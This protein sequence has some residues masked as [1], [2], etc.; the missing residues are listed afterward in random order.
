M[1]SNFFFFGM[2]ALICLLNSSVAKAQIFAV[3]TPVL[4]FTER[5]Y[6]TE[7]HFEVCISGARPNSLVLLEAV[8]VPLTSELRAQVQVNNNGQA[9]YIFVFIHSQSWC[10]LTPI[11]RNGLGLFIARDGNSNILAQHNFPI[12][13]V[14]TTPVGGEANCPNEFVVNINTGGDDLRGRSEAFIRFHFL[15]GSYSDEFPLN[16]GA[17]WGNGSWQTAV[18]P[19]GSHNPD[20]LS[21]VTIRHDGEPRNWPD[22]YDNWNLDKIIINYNNGVNLLN[23]SNQPLVRF[24]GDLRSQYFAR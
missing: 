6:Q 5:P 17:N 3:Q 11:Y 2:L 16:N 18:Y 21:G 22:G 4:S 7:S 23:L 14:F 19:V 9:C 10:A 8:N 15:D 12:N 24:T 13:N 20:T 1:K